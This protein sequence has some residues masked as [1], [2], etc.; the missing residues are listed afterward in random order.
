M[1][2]K[3]LLA[4]LQTCS[5]DQ[6]D[7]G[8]IEVVCNVGQ[9]RDGSICVPVPEIAREALERIQELEE[10]LHVA[11][12]AANGGFVP[13]EF[14]GVDYCRMTEEKRAPRKSSEG[15]PIHMVT[16]TGRFEL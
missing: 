4:E 15:G 3:W 12:V 14:P 16:I 10:Q 7:A 2:I 6:I 1:D 11:A 9:G 5:E 13:P 8:E